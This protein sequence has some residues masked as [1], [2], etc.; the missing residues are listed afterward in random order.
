[1]CK[2]CSGVINKICHACVLIK[3]IK[4]WRLLESTYVVSELSEAY[5]EPSQTTKIEHFVVIVNSSELLTIFAENS[6]LDV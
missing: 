6:I 3:E 2:R 5:S 4:I 1:M